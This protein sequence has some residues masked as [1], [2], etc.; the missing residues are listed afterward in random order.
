MSASPFIPLA[1]A[2]AY[3]YVTE[4]HLIGMIQAGELEAQADENGRYVIEIEEVIRY[5][6]ACARIQLG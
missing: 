3:L 2:A 1:E 5:Q 6:E 4:A